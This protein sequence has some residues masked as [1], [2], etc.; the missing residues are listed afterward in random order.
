MRRCIEDLQKNDRLA[1]REF[2]DGVRGFMGENSIG[3]YLFGS[4]MTGDDT[5]TSDIDVLVLV[6]SASNEIRDKVFDVAFEVNLKYDVYISPRVISRD[7]FEHPV[8]RITPFIKGLTTKRMT[9]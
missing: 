2:A 6:E 3:V 4:K 8:W 7:V 5:P 9:V 1:L